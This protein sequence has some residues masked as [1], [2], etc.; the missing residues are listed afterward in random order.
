MTLSDL[1]GN[2]ICGYCANHALYVFAR[3]AQARAA[4]AW[5][6]RNLHRITYNESWQGNRP[7][8]T[9]NVAFT[10]A[11]L[12][13]LEVPDARL[14]DLEA[15]SAGMAAR[16]SQIGDVGADAPDRWQPGLRDSHVVVTLSACRCEDLRAG[17]AEL[18]GQLADIANGLTTT[19]V[20]TAHKL[21][22]SR[23]HFGFADGFS[24]P[25]IAGASTGPRDGEGKLT[26]WGG[27]RD[28]ALGEF[29][30]GYHDEGGL[31]APA[32]DG[33]LGEDS[34]FMVI[35]KLEQDVAGFRAYVAEQARRLDRDPEWIAAK[36][37]GRWPNGSSLAKYP[38]RPGPAAAESRDTT[39]RFRYGSDPDGAGCPLGAHVRR[40]N[41]RDALGWQGRLT[42]R[43][44]LLRRGISYG[45]P[46]L[47][48]NTEPDGHERGLM[49][50]CFQASLERQFE[51]IQRQWLGDGNVFGLGGDRDPIAAG[52]IESGDRLHTRE[53]MIQGSP[54]LILASLPRFVTMRGGDYFL[55]PGRSGLEALAG[56]HC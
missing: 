49:F 13:A 12:L 31:K 36:I 10:H 32:P 34:T 35:R 47:A 33:A 20:Q 29:V 14:L 9:F 38:E 17:R 41:P 16:A 1:Q 18:E 54:P 23:E 55:L 37:V 26:R 46:Q 21:E 43:H 50:V 40:A 56:G 52:D 27:W 24:Q 48:G 8:L 44:R 19:L 2:V 22:D 30:L 6:A 42:Q 51:F 3:V 7:A 45:P 15:F 28:L 4:R 11:G 5:L 25:A 39:N 53:M